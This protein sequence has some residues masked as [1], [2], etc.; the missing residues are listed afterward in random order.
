MLIAAL[1]TKGKRWKQL[2]FIMNKWINKLWH[3]HT[4]MYY[5]V[6]KRHGVL[7]YASVWM[8]LENMVNERRQTKGVTC[9][10]LLT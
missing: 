5:S 10:I 2:V 3:I 9:M 7:I 4:M 6:I 1:F 8:N